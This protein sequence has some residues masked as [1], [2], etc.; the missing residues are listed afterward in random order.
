[1]VNIRYRQ[2]LTSGFPCIKEGEDVV[3]LCRAYSLHV[4]VSRFGTEV[5][6]N[7]THWVRLR[8][9][10]LPFPLL[11]PVQGSFRIFTNIVIYIL[12]C[13]YLVP[14]SNQCQSTAHPLFVY[15]LSTHSSSCS[16]SSSL[17]LT[18]TCKLTHH[19]HSAQL[20]LHSLVPTQWLLAPLHF[21]IVVVE[22]K[23]SFWFVYC[24]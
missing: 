7:Y 1:M 23:W 15:P 20:A 10:K 2:N 17:A 12:A 22:N 13:M 16:L 3:E 24:I 6:E 19:S 9:A 5:H 11:F 8:T 14:L 4:R 18:L 21:M